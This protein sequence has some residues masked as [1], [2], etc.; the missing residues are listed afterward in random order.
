MNPMETASEGLRA[1][2]EGRSHCWHL[3]GTAHLVYPPQYEEACC[4]GGKRRIRKDPSGELGTHGPYH[5]ENRMRI[6]EDADYDISS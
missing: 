1:T 6:I 2:G 5:P 4:W 3:T